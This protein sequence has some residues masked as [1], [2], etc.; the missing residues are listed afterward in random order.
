MANTIMT[1]IYN[2]YM[3]TYA[4]KSDARLDSHK[5]GELKDIYSNILKMN[6]EAPL[7]ILDRSEETKSFAISLKEDARQLQH[8]IMQSAGDAQDDL[9]KNNIAFSSNENIL[10]AE[11]IGDSASSEDIPTYNIEV[12]SLATPQV[13]VGSFLNAYDRD[14]APGNYSFD[15]NINGMGY[16]FQYSISPDESNYDIQNKL[17]RL[18]NQSNI[19]L[20]ATIV[21]GINNTHSLRIASTKTGNTS[22]AEAAFNPL[23]TISDHKTSVQKGSVEYLGIDYIMSMASNA[24]F[25][26]DGE[27]KS[28]PSN[29][30]TLGQNYLINL[31][32]T[33]G[34]GNE[35]VTIG[36]KPNTESLKHNIH[37]LI[38]GYNSFLQAMG[39]YHSGKTGTS[40]LVHEISGIT[41]LYYN[42][43]DAIGISKAE[44][45]SLSI[46]EDLLTQVAESDEASELL[47][48][49][50]DFSHSL[51]NKTEN[52]SRDPLNYAD[53]T[54]V[55][56][57]NP[58]KNFPSPYATSSYSGLL[59]NYYC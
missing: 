7:Y 37:T 20:S 29:H 32:G 54:I 58:G 27:E 17:A 47:A 9:F 21:E 3:T 31:F 34:E 46:D 33:S 12:K 50:K 43:L 38:G 6:K 23:F 24:H 59:F 11:Y 1:S 52:V 41:N 16:E 42:E 25:T 14:I 56:Y 55:A 45:G 18:I 8:T 49:L 19:G 53:K 57:K 22:A 30:F 35:T 2:H 28:S 13:N 39:E 48:P 26:V 44:D 5:K 36:V 15:V 51:Y 4:P 10:S 40:K